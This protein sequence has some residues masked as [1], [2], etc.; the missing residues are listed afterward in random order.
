MKNILHLSVLFEYNG[1]KT[2]NNFHSEGK[3][4]WKIPEYSLKLLWSYQPTCGEMKCDK[5]LS[6][7]EKLSQTGPLIVF[8]L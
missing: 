4:E 5:R 6:C 2:V 8:S 1:V 3:L 7:C